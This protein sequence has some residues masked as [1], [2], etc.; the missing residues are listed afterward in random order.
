MSSDLDKFNV[1]N[2]HHLGWLL[3]E[4]VP[5]FP[6]ATLCFRFRRAGPLRKSVMA[7]EAENQALSDSGHDPDPNDSIGATLEELIGAHEECMVD[8]SYLTPVFIEAD[9]PPPAN[10]KKNAEQ[11]TGN[12]HHHHGPVTL[13]LGLSKA[14]PADSSTVAGQAEDFNNDGVCEGWVFCLHYHM[15]T[16]DVVHHFPGGGGGQCVRLQLNYMPPESCLNQT[17]TKTNVN[18]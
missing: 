15:S 7:E 5:S 18:G 9:Y 3:E 4:T 16:K 12:D 17:Q 8:E 11:G 14:D 1:T 6:C 13:T 2:T 10:Y